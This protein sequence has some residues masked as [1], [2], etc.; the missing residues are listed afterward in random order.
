M[1]IGIDLGGTK[2]E[3]VALADDGQMLLRQRIPTPRDDYTATLAAIGALVADLEQTLGQRGSVGIGTP[4]AISPFTGRLRNA[5]SVWLN[6]RPL[7]DDLEHLLQ[8]PVRTANDADCFTLSEAS[9]GA[10]ADAGT[11]FG[12]IIGTGTGGGIVINGQ[13]LQGPNAIAGEWGHNPL[14]WPT[15]E[16]LPGPDCYCGKRGCIETFCSGPAL[17]ADLLRASGQQLHGP[18][19]VAAAERGDQAAEAALRRLDDRLARALASV[20]NLLDPEVIVLGGGLSNLHRLYR[21]LPDLMRRH[22]FSDQLA[23]RIVA[24][25][26]GDS[27]G[28]RGAARLW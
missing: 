6:N 26:F 21:N 15:A 28:V 4:G 22:I 1:R 18:A 8:R 14:P 17:S 7:N 10:A 16:E 3:A 11:V 13:L 24:P 12:V 9:D 2:I 25:R 27:S 5:N 19:I 23:T 20:V